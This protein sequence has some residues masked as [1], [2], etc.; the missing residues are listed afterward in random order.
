M[1]SANLKP[2]AMSEMQTDSRRD[3]KALLFLVLTLG[4]A[5]LEVWGL[6]KLF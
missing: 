1:S 3:A 6:I 5:A 2:V 4:L